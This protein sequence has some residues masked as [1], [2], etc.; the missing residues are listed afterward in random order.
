MAEMTIYKLMGV[1][2]DE[3]VKQKIVCNACG[4]AFGK[5]GFFLNHWKKK[6]DDE[7]LRC[8]SCVKNGYFSPQSCCYYKDPSQILYE[9]GMLDDHSIDNFRNNPERFVEMGSLILKLPACRRLFKDMETAGLYGFG[10]EDEGFCAFP[11]CLQSENLKTC[12]MCG[13]ARYCGRVHQRGHW[14][15]IHRHECKGIGLDATNVILVYNSITILSSLATRKSE[16]DN[17]ESEKLVVAGL[18]L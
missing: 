10:G 11:G 16:D 3:K 4:V 17:V 5:S 18:C 1:D 14:K 9:H 6:P 15:V 7:Y 12:T 2:D 8:K 13:T